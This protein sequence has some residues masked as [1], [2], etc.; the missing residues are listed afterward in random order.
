M[1]TLSIIALFVLFFSA[2]PAATQ[3]GA[4]ATSLT[5]A[6]TSAAAVQKVSP[7]KSGGCGQCSVHSS[8]P[9]VSAQNAILQTI[10]GTNERVPVGQIENLI[11]IGIVTV[12]GCETCSARAVNWALQQG[13]SFEDVERALRMVVVMQQ[14][15]CFKG[16]FGPDVTSR[17]EKPLA[18]ARQALEQAKMRASR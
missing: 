15:D 11:P 18:A 14:L 6:A 17:M 1:K 12:L 16:Q 8:S 4:P 5:D 2:R 13:S 7:Q 10:P 3:S 9:E